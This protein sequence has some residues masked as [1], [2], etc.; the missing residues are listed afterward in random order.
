[1]KTSTA[2][3]TRFGFTFHT[4]SVHLARSSMFDELTTL[5]DSVAVNAPAHACY[6]HAI[7]AENCLH[8]RSARSR[9]LT[10]HHLTALYALDPAAPLFRTLRYFW[11]RDAAGRPLLALLCACARD[12]LLR[13]S[14]PFILDLPTDSAIGGS[15]TAAWLAARFPDRFSAATLRSTAQ[16][17]NTSWTRAGHLHG[18][19]AKV[20]TRAVATPGA[21]AFALWLAHLTGA[22]GITALST[23][24]VRLL[25]CAPAG[26]IDLAHDAAAR[27][28]LRLNHSGDVV[29]VAFPHLLT[30]TEQEWLHE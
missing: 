26:V 13:A 1:M 28:W 24:Y 30:P 8:K 17:L 18:R 14:A 29:E 7:L 2:T 20:R 6:R 5:L 3:L 10:A 11:A 19:A 15:A 12:A 27:G 9:A 23:E 16:N 21:A 4:G 25:D 22:R